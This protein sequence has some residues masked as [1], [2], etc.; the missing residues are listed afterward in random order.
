[1]TCKD[2]ALWLKSY[3]E[4]LK[5]YYLGIP[6]GCYGESEFFTEDHAKD[7]DKNNNDIRSCFRPKIKEEFEDEHCCSL[8]NNWVWSEDLNMTVPFHKAEWEVAFEK[9]FSAAMKLPEEDRKPSC[10][11][12]WRKSKNVINLCEG[13]ELCKDFRFSH[14]ECFNRIFY[15]S[16]CDTCCIS[17]DCKDKRWRKYRCDNWVK[18]EE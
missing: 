8:F 6:C 11:K 1:M 7:D 18:P 15:P 10:D 16:L 13:T 17:D 2:C 9:G 3:D 12:C 14:Y 5:N 4:A